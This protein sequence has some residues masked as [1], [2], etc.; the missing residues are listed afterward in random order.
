MFFTCQHLNYL[1]Y[2]V[3]MAIA[4]N[5]LGFTLG[6]VLYYGYR[7]IA[8]DTISINLYDPKQY[9]MDFANTMMSYYSISV[10][11]LLL[12]IFGLF[13]AT[14]NHWCDIAAEKYMRFIDWIIARVVA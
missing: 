7:L 4:V 1:F 9:D 5:A 3:M 13:V 14:L 6:A 10:V 2:V 8:G 12:Y 11:F